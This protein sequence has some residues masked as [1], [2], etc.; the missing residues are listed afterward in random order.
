LV[1]CRDLAGHFTGSQ[2]AVHFSGHAWAA[3]FVKNLIGQPD[4][5]GQALANI[6]MRP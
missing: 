3:N 2:H 5:A 6:Q 4:L 1:D